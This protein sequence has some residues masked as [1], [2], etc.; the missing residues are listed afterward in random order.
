MT[1]ESR[2]VVFRLSSRPYYSGHGLYFESPVFDCETG[3][4]PFRVRSENGSLPMGLHDGADYWTIRLG[5]GMFRLATSRRNALS[6]ID[7]EITAPGSGYWLIGH[8][9]G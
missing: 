9:E 7:V 1:D 3:D 5:R 2:F 4:G 8:H 6:D